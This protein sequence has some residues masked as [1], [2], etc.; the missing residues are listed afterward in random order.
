MRRRGP[1]RVMLLFLLLH[2]IAG[3]QVPSAMRPVRQAPQTADAAPARAMLGPARLADEEAYSI[4][5]TLD[6]HA[7]W[8]LAVANSPSLRE[9]E[10]DVE[11]S[12]GLEVQARKYP[13]PR[14]VYTEDLI[15]SRAAPAG[16]LSMQITQEIVTGG[17]R[18]LDMAIAGRETNA[19]D[20]GLMSRK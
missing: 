18:R 6:L 5:Q 14:F 7:L 3:C 9:A 11:A 17:K 20:L 12:R 1:A 19:A 10:A 15:G 2:A 13:N 16:N 8:R 4:E